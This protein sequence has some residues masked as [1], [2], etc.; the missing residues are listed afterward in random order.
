MEVF[1]KIKEI[2]KQQG[3]TLLLVEQEVEFSLMISDKGY[4]M[5]DGRI[6]HEDE[7]KNLT[8][9]LIQKQYLV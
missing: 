3:L 5:K 6:V 1:E 9:E 8:I 4:I 2:N 7:S